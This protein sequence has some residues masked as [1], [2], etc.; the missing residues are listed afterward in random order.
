M[1]DK[2][3]MRLHNRLFFK[4]YLNYACILTVSALIIGVVFINVYGTTTN[5]NYY[6]QLMD[7][8]KTISNYLQSKLINDD[9][10]GASDYLS[11]IEKINKSKEIWVIPKANVQNPLNPAVQN[12]RLDMD[13][14]QTEFVKVLNEAWEGKQVADMFYSELH[15]DNR[16]V[17]GVPVHGLN[18]EV[19][20]ALV[21]SSRADSQKKVINESIKIIIQSII[22]SLLAS[23]IIANLFVNN[24]TN[25]IL[26]MNNTAKKLA[27]GDYK[28]KTEVNRRDEI[29]QLASTV[30]ILSDRLLE[31]EEE[32]KNME[33]MRMDFFAN[34]SHE[35][36]TPITVIRAY[37]ETLNDRVVTDEVKIMQY[38][39]KILNECQGMERLVGDLLA[40]SKMQNPDF[41]MELEP[42]QI[43]QV[44][45]DTI[46]GAKA[47]CKE[48]AIT[49]DV[50]FEDEGRLILGDYDR[51]RQMFMIIL[52]NAIKF[53][54]ENSKIYIKISSE[55]ILRISIKDEGVGISK[56]ELPYIF[57]KFYR[58]KLRQNAKGSGLGLA[59]AR[60]IALKQNGKIQVYSELGKGT[61]FVFEFPILNESELKEFEEHGY[62]SAV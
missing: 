17:V 5:N 49:L 55:D 52:D 32:R 1:M 35:L 11:N 37:T 14:L 34:V 39:E 41:C 48:K 46:R 24:I 12:I 51:L 57:D 30:D 43:N 15:M 45:E 42:I 26:K 27:D 54:N 62:I 13:M 2:I 60:Q 8:A 9:F 36:R 10:D 19:V 47:L 40:L 44:V 59:I 53:S 28:A 33:Q 16:Y 22:I 29:G 38:Y 20:A 6:S 3:K 25:P 21:Y 23:I 56:E 18:D 4:M 50:K 58:S 61:E 7:E 31:N